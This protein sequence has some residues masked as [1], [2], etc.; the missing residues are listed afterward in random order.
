MDCTSKSKTANVPRYADLEQQE[1]LMCLSPKRARIYF[2]LRAG[3][4]DFKCNRSYKYTDETCR[5]CGNGLENTDHIINHCS[6]IQRS[7]DSFECIYST[8]GRETLELIDRVEQFQ[9][10]LDDIDQETT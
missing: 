6:K 10:L 9:D 4:F 7:A 8:S 5:L 3:V 2:Q 1:Y